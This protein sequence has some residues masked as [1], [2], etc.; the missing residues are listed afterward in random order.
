MAETFKQ[1]PQYPHGTPEFP[2]RKIFGYARVSTDEQ[3][4]QMQVAKLE[5]FGC[6]KIFVE[7][8]SALA[9]NRKQFNIM[10][11]SLREGLR[12][13][14]S[15]QSLAGFQASKCHAFLDR[16]N[17]K[18]PS[19]LLALANRILRIRHKCQNLG[20]V[21][22]IRSYQ[23]P[24]ASLYVHCVC[25]FWLTRMLQAIDCSFVHNVLWTALINSRTRV[26]V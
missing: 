10:L 20:L 3:D 4:P 15:Y 23:S 5:E 2:F 19:R 14:C 24:W 25:Y 26:T 8:V 17:R 7:R 22:C 21:R 12:I 16:T 18:D 9:K 1:H 11:R 6:D 13:E